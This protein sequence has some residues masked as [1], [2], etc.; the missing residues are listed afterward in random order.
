[1]QRLTLLVNHLLSSEPLAAARLQPHA[2]RRVHLSVAGWPT[3]LPAWPELD[4]RVTPAGLLEWIGDAAQGAP[5]YPAEADLRLIAE[6]G[7]PAVALLQGLAGHRPRVEIAGDAAFA[8]DVDWLFDNLRWDIEDDLAK[9][10]GA[11][12]ARELSRVAGW[13]GRG[14]REAAR[15]ASRAVPGAAPLPPR[16]SDI[17]DRR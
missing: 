5:V 6:V 14:I 3:W 8:A 2:G 4:F 13:L 12:P 17:F 16:H 1:M 9:V 7:N 15:L 11:V 10:V